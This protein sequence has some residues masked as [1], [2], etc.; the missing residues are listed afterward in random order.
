M[1]HSVYLG[2]KFFQEEHKLCF[3]LSRESSYKM[4]SI[5]QQTEKNLYFVKNLIIFDVAASKLWGKCWRVWCWEWRSMPTTS[6]ILL[7]KGLRIISVKRRKQKIYSTNCCQS[8]NAFEY[9]WK[10]EIFKIFK[11]FTFHKYSDTDSFSLREEGSLKK[12]A[13]FMRFSQKGVH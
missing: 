11:L 2:F 8:K 10:L 3:D 13:Y 12:T 1:R 7:R 4:Y 9:F 5:L 6:R